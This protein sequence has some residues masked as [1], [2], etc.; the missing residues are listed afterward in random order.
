MQFDSDQE[1]ILEANASGYATGGVLIQ[2]NDKGV[3]YPYAFFSQKNNPAECNYEI[4]KKELLTIIKCI[5]QWS[6]ELQSV[7]R[8]RVLSNHKN[9]T[10]FATH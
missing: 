3:L 5:Y 6:A 10:Y 4:Y 9:L 8:F 7:G 1:T 2:Y